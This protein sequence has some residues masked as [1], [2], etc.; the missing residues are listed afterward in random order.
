[1]SDEHAFKGQFDRARD[2]FEMVI[3]STGKYDDEEVEETFR[4]IRRMIAG[5]RT[6]LQ[7]AE[8]AK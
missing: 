8:A 2:A 4:G 7:K 1:M 3:K 6:K 5:M